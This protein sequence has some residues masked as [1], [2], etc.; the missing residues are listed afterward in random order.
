MVQSMVHGQDFIVS[1][2][3]WCAC[4][5]VCVYVC[6]HLRWHLL[7][8]FSKNALYRSSARED[9]GCNPESVSQQSLFPWWVYL[10]CYIVYMICIWWLMW[11]IL[12]YTRSKKFS[13]KNKKDLG[14]ACHIP[15]LKKAKKQGRLLR[16]ICDRTIVYI[17]QIKQTYFPIWNQF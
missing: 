8:S 10:F 2:P 7:F 4:I 1:Y 13:P 15:P 3:V 14:M 11:L 5:H 12:S 6:V 17:P 9:E 16:C